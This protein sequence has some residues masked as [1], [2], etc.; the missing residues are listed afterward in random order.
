MPIAN[1]P[2]PTARMSEEASKRLRSRVQGYATNP[3]YMLT[4]AGA[5]FVDRLA[6]IYPTAAAELKEQLAI[7]QARQGGVK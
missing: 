4:E 2:A 3:Q 6:T 7:Y 5:N 1:K